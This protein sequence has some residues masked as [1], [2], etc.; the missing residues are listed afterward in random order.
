MLRPAIGD[1]LL[2]PAA[3]H[4]GLPSP[5]EADSDIAGGEPVLRI[6]RVLAEEAAHHRGARRTSTSPMARSA[7]C[8]E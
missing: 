7:T 3:D 8:A 4:Q 1:D 5:K 2:G 6:D